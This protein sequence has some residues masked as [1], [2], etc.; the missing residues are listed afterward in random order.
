MQAFSPFIPLNA[1]DSAL[2]ATVLEFT[3][4]NTSASA[5][6]ATL[7]GWLQ[8][9]VGWYSGER[10]TGSAVRVNRIV[11]RDGST[12]LAC[13]LKPLATAPAPAARDPILLADFEG[14]GYGDWQVEGEAFGPGPARGT[15]DRQ[16]P[17]SGFRG[18]GLVNTYLGGDDRRHGKLS[19]PPFK[20]ERDYL[21][22]LVGGGP[23]K[24]KTCINL[25]VGGQVVRT[26]T[27]QQ[28]ELLKPHNWSVRDLQGKEARIEIV[29][30]E[31]GPWGHINVDQIELRDTPLAEDVTD[32]KLR[33]DFGTM[34]LALLGPAADVALACLSPDPPPAAVFAKTG[35]SDDASKPEERPLDQP[36]TGALGRSLTLDPGQ[37]ATVTFVVSW[38][39][40]NLYR[41]NQR[42][43][44]FGAARFDSA[45]AVSDYIAGNYPRLAGQTR[46]WHDTYYDSTLPYWLLDRLHST[47]A[48]LATTTCQWWDNG[49]FWAWEGCGCCHGTCGHVWNYEHALARLFPQLERS[50][51]E[52]QDFAPGVGLVAAT[53]EIRF[54]GEGWGIWAGDSQ[55][56]YILKAYREHQMSGDNAFLQRLWP[57]IRQAVEFLLA[58][59]ANDDGLLE[60]RQHNTYDIDY[61]GANTMV[62]SLYLARC[63]PRKKWPASWARKN[64]PAAV[65]RCSRRAA[66]TR[67]SGCSTAST[68][69]RTST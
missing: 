32:L 53:G 19:S 9:A 49:R 36:A 55:G 43:G 8:N 30:A 29:D 31:S 62:G 51:R 57:N 54:R 23:H 35:D 65:A 11:R 61:Y 47:V 3:L 20:I 4:K 48:N 37:E 52:M 17:V 39:M 46:L 64:S 33:P 28:E 12:Q 63:G 21:S 24:D 34:N 25:V 1:A 67:S 40:P 10:F 50:T 59:D 68:S 41:G 6:R 60:G 18:K 26:A 15:L 45:E 14:E 13:S 2:P 42:V 7:A 22:F 56:G 44:N 38:H 16:Q 66:G 5:C 27:G 69:S 58:Q